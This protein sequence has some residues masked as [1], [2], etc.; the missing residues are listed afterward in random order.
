[1][2]VVE[3]SATCFA[4]SFVSGFFMTASGPFL[5]GTSGSSGPSLPPESN[6]IKQFQVKD[7]RSEVMGELHA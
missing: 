2:W 4:S 6:V 5:G 1:M 3:E 7:T